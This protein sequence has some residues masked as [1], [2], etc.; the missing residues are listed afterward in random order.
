VRGL[1]RESEPQLYLASAQVPDGGLTFYAP[2]DL[3]V[4]STL[5]PGV[6]APQLRRVI[7]GVDPAQP[8]SD[9]QTLEAVVAA[10][11][12]ARR[13][14]AAALGVF[15]GLAALL[16]AVGLHALLAF[17]V[18]ARAREIGVRVALGAG[19]GHVLRLVATR[20]MAL[21]LSGALT[22]LALGYTAARLLES[23][24]A[25]LSPGDAVAFA[26]AAGLAAVMTLTGSMR[27][28]WRALQVDPG[29]AMRTE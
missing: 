26:A 3:V 23:Q 21:G 2:R 25:G 27:P 11:T 13:T 19:R 12:A 6:L 9:V 14:Q 22:G 29:V 15:A 1:E 7:A 8:V 28:A 24:L 10:D 18:Q 4:K 5:A 16:A 17:G 20:A